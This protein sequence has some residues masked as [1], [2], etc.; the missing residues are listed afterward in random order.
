MPPADSLPQTLRPLA[1]LNAIELRHT[2]WH[3]DVE[4]LVAGIERLKEG[5]EA[6][7]PVATTAPTREPEPEGDELRTVTAL[8]ADIVGSTALGER[9]A[10]DEVKLLVGECVSAMSH[11]VE[12][13]GGTIQAYMG[14]GICAYFGVP[15]AHEDDPERAA[16]AALRIS[17]LASGYATDV[18]AAWGVADFNVR[19]GI[20]TGQ[21]AVGLV[22]AGEQQAVALGDATNVAA[23]LQSLAAPGTIVVGDAT[24]SMLDRFELEPLPEAIVKGREAPVRPFRLVRARGHE[25]PARTTPLVGRDDEVAR[26]RRIVEELRAGRGQVLLVTGE[27]GLGKT[28]MLAELRD[29]AGADVTW[30]VAQCQSFGAVD[31]WPFVDILRRWLGLSPGEPEVAAR[32]K[33]RARFGRL[34]GAGAPA[35][36]DAFAP[37]LGIRGDA[38]GGATREP[39]DSLERSYAAWLETL[40]RERPV[41]LALDDM[42]RADASTRDLAE[43]LLDLCDRAPILIAAATAP[44]P[45]SEGWRFRVRLLSDYAHRATEIPLGPLDAAASEQL[46]RTLLPG[47]VDGAAAHAVV[48]RAEGNPLFLEELLSALIEG[49][50]VQRHRTWTITV[51]ADNLLPMSLENVLL[52]RVDRLGPRSRR[53]AQIAAVIGRTFPVDILEAV[54]ATDNFWDE[55]TPLLRA[56]IVHEVRRSPQLECGFKHGL[57]REAALSTLPAQ[58]R[59]ALYA[60]VAAAFEAVSPD[61]EHFERLAHYYAQSGDLPRALECVERAA[62]AAG[63]VGDGTRASEL[64]RN[65]DALRTRV[66]ERDPARPA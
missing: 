42:H 23:R 37:L 54:A 38:A 8:F 52:A 47:A 58:R 33:A 31:S 15:T 19:V 60:R 21:A 43:H 56:E 64:Q 2:R 50:G 62:A 16:R 24:A 22:G 1:F 49:A 35:V 26:L 10:P 46:L 39:P 32:T 34:L 40:A 3:D 41:V 9:L 45:D 28:R 53:L 6:A 44:V 17:E 18:A 63:A 29:I 20:N 27:A 25:S 65:A 14:D 55:F 13:Y 66:A 11:A 7:Q 48:S 12:E 57:L 36:L 61:G 5:A 30:L 4:R 59:R 51:S